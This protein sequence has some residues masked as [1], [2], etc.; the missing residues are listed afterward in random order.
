MK[1]AV[2]NIAI[3]LFMSAF[4]FTACKKDD[5]KPD[6]TPSINTT[7]PVFNWRTNNTTNFSSDSTFCYQS[8]TTIF[9]FKNGLANSIE[10]N[11]SSLATGTYTISSATGNQLT[12]VS[13]NITHTASSGNVNITTNANNKLSGTVNATFSSGTIT[14][15]TG[16]FTDIP[17]R[18]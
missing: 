3:S 4:I 18:N 2:L 11:L 14:V 12:L 9:A 5:A 15:L 8:F 16:T 10:I 17:K 1:K 13:S 6:E 7:P